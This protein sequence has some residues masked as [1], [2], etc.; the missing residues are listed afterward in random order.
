MCFSAFGICSDLKKVH[1]YKNW[2]AYTQLEQKSTIQLI[3]H[4]KKLFQS[5]FTYTHKC[6]HI[7]ICI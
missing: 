7:H 2:N 1:G 6:I 5:T 4:P 3:Q